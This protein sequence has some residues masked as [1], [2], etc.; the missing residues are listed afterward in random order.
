MD[1]LWRT[2]R[3]L[4]LLEEL[5]RAGS[6]R[7]LRRYV[8]PRSWRRWRVRVSM[9][10]ELWRVVA[11]ALA[12]CFSQ[13]HSFSQLRSFSQLHRFLQLLAA[14]FVSADPPCPNY[15]VWAKGEITRLQIYAVSHPSACFNRVLCPGIMERL[16]ETEGTEGRGAATP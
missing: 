3:T 6:L 5:A 8:A 11:R 9:S 2:W 7:I 15:G 12:R 16:H 14:F 13:L 1:S 10:D 4:A